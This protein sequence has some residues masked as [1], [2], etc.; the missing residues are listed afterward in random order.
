MSFLKHT[1]AKLAILSVFLISGTTFATYYESDF[2]PIGLTGLGQ[3]SDSYWGKRHPYGNTDA[4]WRWTPDGPES[5]EDHNEQDLIYSLGVNC[6]GCED[7]D[8][9]DLTNMFIQHII[10]K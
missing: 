2:F 6:I 8:G 1:F 4:Q 3:T 9:I 10:K 5:N 7:A